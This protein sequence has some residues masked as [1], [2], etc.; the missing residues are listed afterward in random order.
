MQQQHRLHWII[1]FIAL[2]GPLL[3]RI[4]YPGFYHLFDVSTFKSW[5]AFTTPWRN[6]YLT[7]C[8]CNYPIVGLLLST[9]VI[10]LLGNSI[11]NYL[12][13]SACIDGINVIVIYLILKRL[14]IEKAILWS[15][16]IGILLSTWVG[17]FLWGQI[18]N[19][20]QL[21]LYSSCFC[22]LKLWQEKDKKNYFIHTLF[23]LSIL[24]GLLTKQLLIFSLTGIG[25]GYLVWL[26]KTIPLKTSFIR[27]ICAA[28]GFF[29]PLLLIELWVYIPTEYTFF[30][31]EKIL[32]TGSDHMEIISGNGFNIWTILYSDQNMSSSI[33]LIAWLTPMHLGLFS[34][35]TYFS[36]ITLRLIRT[37]VFTFGTIILYIGLI[38]L[39]MNVFFTGTHERY[40]Y[41]CYPFILMGILSTLTYR[42]RIESP[43][44]FGILSITL[45]CATIYGMFVFGV[46]M[47]TWKEGYFYQSLIAHRITALVHLAY[48]IYITRF[49]YQEHAEQRID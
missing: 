47:K 1:F 33:P 38:N 12:M 16:I 39:A 5:S 32:A 25:I 48:F 22:L 10:E 8:Y 45:V 9:G 36:F 20:G 27:M 14:G 28:S 19:I 35:F 11:T 15:G 13:F 18:D 34:F 6:V 24:A 46:L 40:L 29:I 2:I 7:T 42:K 44:Y 17:G 31:L 23:G 41:H 3:T 21:I 26:L 37:Q 30:H 43:N 4:L 49:Y